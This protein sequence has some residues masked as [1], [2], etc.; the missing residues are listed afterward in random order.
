MCV[1]RI[2]PMA[3]LVKGRLSDAGGLRFESQGGIY[4]YIYIYTHTSLS[5]S[6]SI[7]I[8]IYMFIYIYIYTYTYICV[9]ICVYI[10]GSTPCNQGPPASRA[11]RGVIP[12]YMG[13]TW[14]LYG[15][16][17]ERECKPLIGTDHKTTPPSQNNKRTHEV[18]VRR[19]GRRAAIPPRGMEGGQPFERK[20]RIRNT[21]KTNNTSI[22]CL[23]SEMKPRHTKT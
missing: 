8:Y 22:S 7:Y 9:R 2:A 18:C 23:G 11:P 19:R 16:Y 10:H 14:G 17:M 5:L 13:P 20:T 4:I 21:N 15:A 6:L 3:Q 12:S 1:R